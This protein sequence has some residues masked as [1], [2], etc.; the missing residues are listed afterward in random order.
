M[1][2]IGLKPE[3]WVSK[4]KEW[5]KYFPVTCPFCNTDLILVHRDNP[6][7]VLYCRNHG[8]LKVYSMDGFLELHPTLESALRI[9][10]RF[11]I[12]TSNM[13]KTERG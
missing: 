6:F 13:R 10:T 11:P 12:P 5:F 9:D 8:F 4:V 1:D 2:I 7:D 3:A